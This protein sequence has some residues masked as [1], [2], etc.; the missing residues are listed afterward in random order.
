MMYAQVQ[1]N[2]HRQQGTQGRGRGRGREVGTE[3][4]ERREEEGGGGSVVEVCVG[5]ELISDSSDLTGVSNSESIVDG[6]NV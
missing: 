1:S 2:P 5:A 6:D 3:G 4:E